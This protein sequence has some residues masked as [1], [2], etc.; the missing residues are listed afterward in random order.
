MKENRLFIIIK[1]ILEEKWCFNYD[2]ACGTCGMINVKKE[3]QKYSFE[4]IIKSYETL[5]FKNNILC[6][7][8]IQELKKI[9]SLI[10]G[11]YTVYNA[12]FDFNKLDE[13]LTK[14][15]PKNLLV[16]SL[17]SSNNKSNYKLSAYWWGI[18]KKNR[19]LK[20]L[21]KLNW[22]TTYIKLAIKDF[23]Y[24]YNYICEKFH[25]KKTQNTNEIVKNLIKKRN[26]KDHS[27]RGSQYRI[28]LIEKLEQLNIQQRLEYLANDV[29]HGIKFYPSV[30][31][32]EAE[33]ILGS[34]SIIT[35][36]K[37][38]LKLQ[39]T[40]ARYGPWSRFQKSLDYYI[41]ITKQRKKDFK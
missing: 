39:N 12:L 22:R 24:H 30:L 37:L 5:D 18:E 16:G 1:K 33:N 19:I 8:Y 40:R 32:V 21:E 41:R 38:L 7:R 9:Y 35:L 2:G 15:Y 17:I 28:D 34:F 31:V 23:E 20:K 29:K 3:L 26:Q 36:K 25:K 4:E 14:K 6:K 27:L 11:R 13:K 10:T